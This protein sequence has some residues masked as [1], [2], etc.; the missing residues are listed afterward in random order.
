MRTPTTSQQAIL[1]GSTQSDWVRVKVKDAGGTFRDLTTYPGFNAVKAV[2]W[3]EKIE[4]PHMTASITL[5]RE[6]YKLSLSPFVAGSALN[7]GW[8][9]SANQLLALNREIVIEV[10]IV[11]ADKQPGTGDWW[12]VFYGKI[13]TLDAASGYDIEIT[14]RDL[15]GR[16]AQQFIKTEKVWAYFDDGGDPI[17]LKIWEPGMVVAAGLCILPASRGDDD[18]GKDKVLF[19]SQAGTTGSTEPTWTTGANQVDGSAKWD[20]FAPPVTTGYDVQTIIQKIAWD[21]AAAGDDLFSLSTPVSPGWAITQFLQS[22]SFVLEACRALS[23]QIGWDLR[24]LFGAATPSVSPTAPTW[25][26]YQP[27][28][29]APSVAFTFQPSDYGAPTKLAL[30]IALIRNAWRVIYA[31]K[32]SLWPD[33]TPKRKVIEVSDSASIAKYGELWAEIVE[34][35]NSNIDSSTEAT[36]LANAALSDCKEPTAEFSVPL[37]RAF[38][39]AQLNDYYTFKADGVRSDSDL[40]L[41]VTAIDHSCQIGDDGKGRIHTKLDC[42]GLPTAGAKVHLD[43]TAHPNKETKQKNAGGS[44]KFTQFQAPKTG[45]VNYLDTIGGTKVQIVV[46]NDGKAALLEEYEIHVST[47]P[48]FTPDSSTLVGLTKGRELPLTNLEPGT[49]YYGQSVPRWYNASRLIRGTPSKEKSFVAGR[50]KTGHIESGIALGDYPLNG[51]FETRFNAGSLPDHWS[52]Y[53]GAYSTNVEVM[54]DGNGLSGKRYVRLKNGGIRSAIYPM[55][56]EAN[57]SSRRGSIYRFHWW[58]KSGSGVTGGTTYSALIRLLNYQDSEVVILT[59]SST[60]PADTKLS[61]WVR[62]ELFVRL[63]EGDASARSLQLILSGGSTTANRQI[64]I[65]EVRCQYLGTA[66][67][68][69]GDTTYFTEN[70][71]AVPGFTNS[72]VN[73][74]GTCAFR[75]DQFGIVHLK[76]SMKNGTVGAAAFTLPVGF[77]PKSQKRWAAATGF[78]GMAE[79]QVNTNGTVISASGSNSWV[80]LDGIYFLPTDVANTLT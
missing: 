76:G 69:I 63:R 52:L 9:S 47:S 24:F 49:T 55:L 25:T 28:R 48:G 31:D 22:R 10:A 64:D 18:S 29:S 2:H 77:R 57:E 8:G 50:A 13:D 36:T 11:A 14:A 27:V 38:P 56:Q 43:K 54:E 19:C 32:A 71:E 4:D 33:G 67:I 66:W 72:W 74:V 61:H 53:S 23:S 51:G 62:E 37:M 70:Y 34:D 17:G 26:L 42:R 1:N 79:L 46:P 30:D 7:K 58:R 16:M 59:V 39:W 65:D 5:A 20:Y 15:A 68:E 12:T 35:E 41:A 78:G 6:L 75:K 21:N 40:S 73:D 3:R 45:A 60:I 80:S 44:H